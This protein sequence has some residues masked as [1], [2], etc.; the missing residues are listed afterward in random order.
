MTDT[1]M[2]NFWTV[3]LDQYQPVLVTADGDILMEAD[4]SLAEESVDSGTRLHRLVGFIHEC[5]LHVEHTAP[6]SRWVYKFGVSYKVVEQIVYLTYWKNYRLDLGIDAHGSD[7][8]A[9]I[10]FP[11]QPK[12]DYV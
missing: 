9:R 7:T 1:Q 11:N 2:K 4:F 12:L 10:H 3:T 6:D 8:V 5:K